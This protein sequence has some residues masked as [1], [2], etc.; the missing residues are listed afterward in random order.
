MS[1]TLRIAFVVEGPTDFVMLKSIV[2]ALLKDRDFVSQ[3]LQPEIS[4]AFKT[5]PGRDGGWPGVF[6]W[7]LQSADQGAAG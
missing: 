1:D 6:R 7:C 3:V 2:K 4:E 5:V